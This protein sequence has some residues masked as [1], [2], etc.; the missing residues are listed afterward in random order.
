MVCPEDSKATPQ[1]QEE[2]CR[3][4]RTRCALN[5]VYCLVTVVKLA[6]SSFLSLWTRGLLTEPCILTLTSRRSSHTK[7]LAH[8]EL[9]R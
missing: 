5:T 1:A 7:K 3:Q 6:K 4:R 9:Q 2:R 8:T